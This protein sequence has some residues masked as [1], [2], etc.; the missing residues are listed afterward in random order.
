MD[1]KD[2]RDLRQWYRD[3]ALRAKD[4]G[5]DIVYAYANHDDLLHNFQRVGTNDRTDEYGGS[6]Q[7]RAR[8]LS[9]TI[10]VLKEAV[11]ETMAVAVRF[12]ADRRRRRF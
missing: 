2:F 12:S 7:N 11:G 3:A 1:K 9:E 5:F 8:L 10:E 6:V 4:A